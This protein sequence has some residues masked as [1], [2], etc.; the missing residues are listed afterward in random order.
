M[1]DLK[2]GYIVGST[3]WKQQ[4]MLLLG[5]VT[6]SLII[7]P[8]MELLFNVYGIGGVFPRP[9]MDP[10]Q[11]LAAPPAALMAAVT[12]AVFNHKLPWAMIFV[13]AGIS[14]FFFSY[15][16]FHFSFLSFLTFLR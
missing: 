8:I 7:P 10:Q 3:P 9:N 16:F 1:Q 14:A 13:G 15:F 4:V 6:A 5:V 12:Q 2:V 11:M